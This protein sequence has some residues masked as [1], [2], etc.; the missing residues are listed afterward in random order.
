MPGL[1]FSVPSSWWALN[2][3]FYFPSARILL[4]DVLSFP[5]PQQFFFFELANVSLMQT[6]ANI[7][8]ISLGFTL[9]WDLDIHGRFIEKKNG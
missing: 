2:S 8:L 1:F 7:R 3:N 4:K 9:L 6:T 5:F